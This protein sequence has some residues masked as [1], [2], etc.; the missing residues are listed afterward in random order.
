V[1]LLTDNQQA[2]IADSIKLESGHQVVLLDVAGKHGVAVSDVNRNIYRIGSAD[3]I[4]WQV[5]SEGTI[6]DQ[7][8]FVALRKLSDGSIHVRRFFGS[9]FLLDPSNGKITQTGW[10][11]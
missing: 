5:S 1:H 10:S 11:K 4:I 7:D 9:E 8:S 3:Q 6:Y 2:L